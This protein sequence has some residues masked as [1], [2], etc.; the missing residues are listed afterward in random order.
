M[1][2]GGAVWRGLYC[3]NLS[4]FLIR[5]CWKSLLV[6]FDSLVLFQISS[7][8]NMRLSLSQMS[9]ICDL[10]PGSVIDATMFNP[11]GYSMNGMKADV[12]SAPLKQLFRRCRPIGSRD[13][14]L[15]VLFSPSH[16][17]GNILDYSHHPGTRVLLCQL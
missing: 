16:Q 10:I 14:F 3:C 4:S 13:M 6:F 9:G 12:S 17:P 7:A 8:V 15:L 5:K 2:A 11:C 1:D